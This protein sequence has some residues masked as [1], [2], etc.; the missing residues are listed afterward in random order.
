M[1]PRT[2]RAGLC[3]LGM[4]PPLTHLKPFS[5]GIAFMAD[6]NQGKPEVKGTLPLYKKPEPLN[7]QSHKGMGLKY[8]D[9][10][11]DFLNETHFVPLT[12]GEIAT[13][14]AHYP[15]IFLGDARLPVAVMG[16]QQGM[17]LFVDPATGLYEPMRYM[18]GYVR[19]YPFVSAMH[20]EESDRFTVCV[21]SASHLM[22]KNPD[23][24][25]FDDKDEP[26]E[27][28]KNAIEFVRM[29]EGEAAATN[30]MLKRFKELDLFEE[31]TTQFQPRDAQ[32][33]P[34]GQA[35][36]I[37]TYWGISGEK[38]RALPAE[39]LAELRDNMY[40]AIIYAHMISLAQWDFILTR[41]QIRAN[42]VASANVPNTMS[43]PPP[44][45]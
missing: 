37:A 8:G 15:V 29:Y 43:P 22:S 16:L 3:C 12:A 26:T 9:R 13:A 10:P 7:L 5:R 25:F 42:G 31:Q 4:L 38:M 40:L 23:E 17:N 33:Q 19:R 34:T 32:G 11:F 39:T 24:P 21:D 41:A 45:A 27:F 30:I 1:Q 35:Q 14:S 18:P 6:A 20:T 2:K 36:T 44:E 28:T